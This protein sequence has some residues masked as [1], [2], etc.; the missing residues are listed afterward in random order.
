MSRLSRVVRS[1]LASGMLQ[2]MGS[3]T[4]DVQQLRLS[5]RIGIATG[6]L[7]YG[8]NLESCVVT[9]RAKSKAACFAP[10]AE[11]HC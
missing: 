10:A 5:V 6:W 11:L 3:D 8:N 4:Q 1:N 2:P 7:P 9:E